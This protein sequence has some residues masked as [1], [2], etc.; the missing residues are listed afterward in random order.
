MPT[1][2]KRTARVRRG[3]PI[4]PDDWAFLN[5]EKPK[6]PFVALIKAD[7]RWCAL[8]DAYGERITNE[9]VERHPGTRPTHWW[10]F[11]AP[12]LAYPYEGL[13][14]WLWLEPRLQVGGEPVD[15]SEGA[16]AH[17]KAIPDW[18]E[19][20]PAYI[21]NPPEFESERAYLKRHDLPLPGEASRCK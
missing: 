9:W 16:S 4:S 19:E 3:P 20:D 11:S 1:N 21:T 15:A 7:S 17:R 6:N 5:D 10:K 2:R 8:W 14:C 13:E 18:D 12:R